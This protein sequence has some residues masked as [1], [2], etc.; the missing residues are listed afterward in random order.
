MFRRELVRIATRFVPQVF[1]LVMGSLKTRI[2][3]T[4]TFFSPQRRSLS[5]LAHLHRDGFF[6]RDKR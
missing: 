2:I 6:Q 4:P 3:M 5:S 1:D